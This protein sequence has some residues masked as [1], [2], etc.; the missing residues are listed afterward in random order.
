MTYSYDPLDRVTSMIWKQGI[1]PAF[2]SWAYTHNLRGQRTSITDITGRSAAY[3]YDLAARLAS[4]TVANDPGGVSFNGAISYALDGTGNRLSRTS[5]LAAVGSATYDY[6]ANDQLTSDTY[7][8]NG[9]AIS[10][11]GHTYAYDFENRLVSKDGTG[12]TVVYD[13]DGNRV[14]KTAGGVTTQYLV[15]D[16]NPTR[17]LQVLEEVS[18]DSVQKRYTYGNNLLSQTRNV[19]GV[20]ATSYYGYDAHGSIAFL[21]DAAGIVTD[22]Y[23]YDAWGILVASTGTTP[24][25]RRYVG[26]EFDPDLGLINLRARQY[27]PETGRFQTIDPLL[28]FQ[29]QPVTFNRYLYASNDPAN[30]VDPSGRFTAGEYIAIGAFVLSVLDTADV[31]GANKPV[32]WCLKISTGFGLLMTLAKVTPWGGL[33]GI[34]FSGMCAYFNYLGQH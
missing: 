1:S 28:G 7:D 6:D 12:V 14:A 10:S 19:S 3:G 23:D 27:K 13:C 30:L 4:E 20:P 17:Y 22:S 31:F 34:L 2:A 25:T 15:D 18:G 5:T 11:G 8:A 33:V 24:N 21:A 9:N 29:S 32:K 26:E 16:L